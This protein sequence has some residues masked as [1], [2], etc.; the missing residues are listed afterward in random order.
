MSPEISRSVVGEVVGSAA[1]A[2]PYRAM[3]GLCLCLSSAF[4]PVEGLERGGILCTPS[5]HAAPGGLEAAARWEGSAVGLR[6]PPA[7]AG[8][9]AHRASAS[10]GAQVDSTATRM[11]VK[12]RGLP[13]C[14][15]NTTGHLGHGRRNFS[16]RM[17]GRLLRGT[18]GIA[19]ERGEFSHGFAGLLWLYMAD[20]HLGTAAASPKEVVESRDM[21]TTSSPRVATVKNG[22]GTRGICK[23]PRG[24]GLANYV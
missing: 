2:T 10:G 20:S 3:R 12:K 6:C 18:S 5:A 22:D 19:A 7:R 16:G 11:W 9:R 13:H 21:V 17:R 15:I 1:G 8:G 24:S 4:K 23:Y 14:F